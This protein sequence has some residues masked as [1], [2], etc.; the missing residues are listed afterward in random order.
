MG[1]GGVADVWF[2]DLHVHAGILQTNWFAG[3]ARFQL[4]ILKTLFVAIDGYHCRDLRERG[5]RCQPG[6]QTS[7]LLISPA[8]NSLRSMIKS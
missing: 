3:S 7:G 2:A 5:G 4:A 8:G 6:R 1:V